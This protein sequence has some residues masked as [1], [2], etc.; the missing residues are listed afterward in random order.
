MTITQNNKNTGA[1]ES[2]A[3]RRL[4]AYSA[5][6][7]HRTGWPGFEHSCSW[8]ENELNR[9]GADVE[10]QF[11][12]FP[13]YDAQSRVSLN[14][15]IVDS[16]PLYYSATGKYQIKY[17]LVHRI[18]PHLAEL[19]LDG[20]IKK[21]IELAIESNCDGLVLVTNNALGELVAINRKSDSLRLLPVILIP[22]RTLTDDCSDDYWDISFSARLETRRGSNL[23]ARFGDESDSPI[24][25][26]TPISGWFECAGERGTGIAIALELALSLSNQ[27]SVELLLAG[28]HEL[29]YLGGYE[30]SMNYAKR[31][32]FIFHLGSCLAT[33]AASLEVVCSAPEIQFEEI[34]KLLK[35]KVTNVRRPSNPSQKA[36]WMGES[37]CWACKNI[38]MFSIAGLNDLFHT[39][40]DCPEAASSPLLLRETID[41]L[42]EVLD[43]MV[44]RTSYG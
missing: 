12:S 5:H 28:G 10:R 30:F 35:G 42:R 4:R 13:F 31:P 1:I 34:A 41:N 14:G 3:W 44:G 40:A 37:E 6:G 11:W 25:I 15:D 27:F 39:P 8:L 33:S 19:E 21:L 23:V 7:I 2:S 18:D 29:G 17:P 22:G 20:Q 36:E 26:T 38:P 24:V 32:Q 16:M 9:A 43:C